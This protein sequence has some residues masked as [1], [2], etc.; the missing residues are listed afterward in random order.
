MSRIAV[1][2]GRV[3]AEKIGGAFNLSVAEM[4][5]ARKK[6]IRRRIYRIN[7]CGAQQVGAVASVFGA[8]I[9][10]LFDERHV[11]LKRDPINL[12]RTVAARRHEHRTGDQTEVGCTVK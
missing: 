8:A 12:V 9:L 3:A 11:G 7:F 5:I 2:H 6:G 1:L 4:P 10:L